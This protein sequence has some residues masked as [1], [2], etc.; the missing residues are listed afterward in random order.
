MAGSNYVL[1]KGFPVLSTYNSS[2]ANGVQRFRAVVVN[3]SGQIDL[4]T[5]ATSTVNLVGV[6]QED[7]DATKVATGK[8]AADVRVLGISK[9]VV[10]TATSL[11]I[12]VRVMSG[13]AGG[14][15][16]AATAGSRVLG[17][18][19]GTNATAA[20]IVAGDIVDVL[21]TPGSHFA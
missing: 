2:S 19:V 18:I 3:S 13:S 16:V 15:I 21:L 11:A 12:G 4:S 17:I 14:A 9:V 10:Q 8:A 7:I 6:V 5:A 20:T 1:D